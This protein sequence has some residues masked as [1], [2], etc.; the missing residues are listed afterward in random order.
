MARFRTS[1]TRAALAAWALAAC[2]PAPRVSLA[3]QFGACGP[4]TAVNLLQVTAYAGDGEHVV[5]AGVDEPIAIESFPLSTTQIGMTWLGAGG[6]VAFAGKSAPIDL[7]ALD[8]GAAIP[9]FV[10]PAGGFCPVGPM[11]ESRIQ[12]LVARAGDDVLIVGGLAVNPDG[13][14][15]APLSSV[16]R[17]DPET[18]TFAAVKI[19]EVLADA[20]GFTGAALTALRDGRIAVIGGPQRAFSIYDPKTHAFTDAPALIDFRLFHAALAAADGTVVVAGGCAAL[21]ASGGCMAK[22]QVVGYTLGRLGDPDLAL[23]RTGE[24][25]RAP[26]LFE[27]GEQ[28]DGVTRYLLTGGRAS[29]ADRFALADHDAALL[30]GGRN[31]AA[32]LDG[33]AALT[34]FTV[35]ATG[36]V[37]DGAAAIYPAD[38]GPAVAVA[39][40]PRLDGARLIALEDGRAAAF[41]RD[42]DHPAQT[43]VALHDPTR[44]TWATTAFASPAGLVAPSLVRLD[45]GAILVLAGAAW[46]YRPSLVGPASGTTTAVPGLATDT[47]VL[48]PSDPAALTIVKPPGR[49]AIDEW[50]LHLDAQAADTP[51]AP[52]LARALVG[53]PRLATG[54]VTAVVN[55]AHGGLGLIAAQTAPGRALVA[56]VTPGAASQVV[57]LGD[58]AARRVCTGAVV[59]ALPDGTTA[60]FAI[61]PAG[62]D[63]AP[64]ATLTVNGAPVVRCAVPATERGAWGVAAIHPE[65]GLGADITVVSVTVARS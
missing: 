53:G 4:P 33:G 55:V 29:G 45:D 17:F 23:P 56:L 62:A 25:R 21:D 35:D 6:A 54:S 19:P 5:S 22:S 24:P 27:L 12:P 16:E 47:T 8:D 46:L 50:H 15:G 43:V 10:A 58:G 26:Q 31:E 18:Q 61:A 9:V 42:H 28:R 60:T 41:G 63:R 64:T 14:P 34:A 7:G 37:V 57:A 39:S 32:L 48:T 3:P 11:V 59:G 49:P 20:N 30:A 38:G 36:A 1:R 13:T 51:G 65:A 52:A 40:A 44:N 2:N